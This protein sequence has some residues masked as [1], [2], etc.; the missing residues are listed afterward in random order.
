MAGNVDLTKSALQVRFRYL[1]PKLHINL[2]AL[3]EKDSASFK[4]TW[5][6][7]SVLACIES[8]RIRL[9]PLPNLTRVPRSPPAP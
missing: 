9:L 2:L 4:S 5:A 3:S 7:S 1:Q 8:N 6:K